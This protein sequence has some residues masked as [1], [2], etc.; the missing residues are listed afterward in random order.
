MWPKNMNYIRHIYIKWYKVKL[1]DCPRFL[2]TVLISISIV[3]C[4][5]GL[6]KIK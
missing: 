1:R 4:T 2:I 3:H 6:T 5:F